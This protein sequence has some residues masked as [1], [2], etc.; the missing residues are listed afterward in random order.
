VPLLGRFIA[1]FLAPAQRLVIEIDGPYHALRGRMC[2]GLR[3]SRARVTAFFASMRRLVMRDIEAAI[4][5]VR[6]ALRGEGP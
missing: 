2:A 6:A 4:S 1:D 3:R 5:R